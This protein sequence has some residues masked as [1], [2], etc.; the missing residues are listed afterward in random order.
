MAVPEAGPALTPPTEKAVVEP[1]PPQTTSAT[2]DSASDNPTASSGTEAANSDSSASQARSS[3]PRSGRF[4]LLAAS[5]AA[6]ALI[7]AVAGS[8]AVTLVHG[9]AAP[10]EPKSAAA[11][12]PTIA[13]LQTAVGSLR[14]ELAALRTSIEQAGKAANGQFA[15]LAERIDRAD[16]AQAEPAA[17]LA[18][19]LETV[20]K[21]ERQAAA[22]PAP[23]VTGS[24]PK[25]AARDADKPIIS[26]WSLRRVYDGI[27]I[28][29]GRRGIAEVE[30]G[31]MLPGAGRVEEIK[32]IDGRWVVVTSRGLIVPR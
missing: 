5:V 11:R 30:P 24:I 23:D 20:E 21:L 32:R 19:I 17:K 8:L 10:P 27:A 4:A 3:A 15:K 13:E 1:P 9:S 31:I 2:I 16:K 6:A 29:E 22:A 14:Q 18:K 12:A 25:P 7:G 28:L 26:D